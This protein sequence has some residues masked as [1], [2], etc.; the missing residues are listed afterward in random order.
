[1]GSAGTEATPLAWTVAADHRHHHARGVHLG[2]GCT[3]ELAPA[4]VVPATVTKNEKEPARRGRVGTSPSAWAR[5]SDG[6]RC[7]ERGVRRRS[8]SAF[9]QCG[10]AL[11][12][13]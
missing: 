12:H 13:E 7:C 11:V 4:P 1:L 10:L 9:G 8:E 3:A 5:S 2:V 6:G